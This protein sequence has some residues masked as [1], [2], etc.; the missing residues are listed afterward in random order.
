MNPAQCQRK[1]KLKQKKTKQVEKVD[2]KNGNV[3][4]LT[5]L[6]HKLKT[7]KVENLKNVDTHIDKVDKKGET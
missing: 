6:T 5:K 3:L 1:K 4:T 2:A 7:K